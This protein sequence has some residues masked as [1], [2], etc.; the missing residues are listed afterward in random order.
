VILR[1]DAI[2]SLN[3][4]KEKSLFVA[5]VREGNGIFEHLEGISI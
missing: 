5:E 1:A 3:R 4:I 2:I